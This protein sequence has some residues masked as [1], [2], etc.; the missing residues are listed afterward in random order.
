MKL[1]KSSASNSKPARNTAEFGPISTT[2][3]SSYSFGSYEF[4]VKSKLSGR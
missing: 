3:S 2:K 4:L 1:L